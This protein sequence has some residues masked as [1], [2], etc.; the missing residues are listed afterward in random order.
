MLRWVCLALVFCAPLR[1][2][3][4]SIAT[5]TAD[6]TVPI[7]HGIMGGLWKSKTVAAPLFAKGIVLIGGEKPVVFVSVDWCEIR[8]EAF[9]RWRDALAEA[10]GTTRERVLVSAIHQHEAPVADLEAQRILERLNL[11]GSIC[12][13]K[14]HEQAVQRVARAAKIAMKNRHP[15]T[16]IGMG[17]AKVE[18]IASNRRYVLPDGKISFG[19]GSASG[20]N[21]LAANAPEGTIA[22]WLKTLSSGMVKRPSR[23]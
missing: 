7:G 20:R 14:F 23:P 15:I 17:Q 13:L 21:V 4:F 11:E 10:V 3:E 6:V 1:A 2:A 18:K 19:R 5:F 8:N 9:D 22:P 12:D 16:D